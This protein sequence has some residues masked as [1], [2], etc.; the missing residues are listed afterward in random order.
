MSTDTA[1]T[2]FPASAVAAQEIARHRAEG[3]WRV[4]ES[5]HDDLRRGAETHPDRPAITCGTPTGSAPDSLTY[6]ELLERVERV[7]AA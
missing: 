4:E 3:L 2:T 1:P 6:S 5:I 7:A